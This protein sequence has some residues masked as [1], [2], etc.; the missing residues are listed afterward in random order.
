MYF[1]IRANRAAR[2]WSSAEQLGRVAW[3][4]VWPL[5]RFSPRPLWRWRVFLLKLFGARIGRHVH[6]HP[7]VSVEIPWNLRIGRFS[8]VGD[9]AILYNLGMVQI[10][11]S[12]TISQ[13]AHLCAGTHDY[14]TPEFP[15]VKSRISIGDNVWI[16]ADAFIG[17]GVKIEDRAI[18]GARAVVMHDVSAGCIVAGNPAVTIKRRDETAWAAAAR[19]LE[20]GE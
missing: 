17:P 15:L 8:A 16:C 2:K 12:T 18:A 4:L 13:G 11:S 10:G 19:T 20:K 6:I 5:F 14:R 7:S 3:A 9:R 1:D